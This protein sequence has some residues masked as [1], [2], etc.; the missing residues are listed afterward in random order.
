MMLSLFFVLTDSSHFGVSLGGFMFHILSPFN[1]QHQA[2]FFT[3][4][5]FIDSNPVMT[6]FITSQ[7]R[8]IHVMDKKLYKE[9][10][11]M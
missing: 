6:S 1:S 4:Q 10:S 11:S 2:L 9:A 3:T 7:N 8:Q 5:M